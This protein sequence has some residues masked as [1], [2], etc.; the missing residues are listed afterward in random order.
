MFY[1]E[2]VND[3]HGNKLN[4][5]GIRSILMNEGFRLNG[6][7]PKIGIRPTIDGRRRGARESLEVQTMDMAKRA[8][9]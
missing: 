7:L 9:N 4:L 8:P 5:Y 1:I 6:R 3:Y 2:F